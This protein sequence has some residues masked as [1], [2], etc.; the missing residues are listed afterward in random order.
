MVD[1]IYVNRIRLDSLNAQSSGT[2]NKQ[3][4]AAKW[5]FKLSSLLGSG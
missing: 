5:D 2:L 4:P 3:A 1:L